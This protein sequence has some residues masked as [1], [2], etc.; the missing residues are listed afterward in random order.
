MPKTSSSEDFKLST[1]V[2]QSV[3]GQKLILAS[4]SPTRIKL[5]ENA[6]L[7]FMSQHPNIDEAAEQALRAHFTANLLAIE[8]AKL[9]A[10]SIS[11]NQA[12]IIGA[13]QTL[14]CCGITYHKPKNKAEAYGQ[15]TSLR[16]KTHTLT[17]AVAISY[18]N[19]ILWQHSMQAH[20]TMRNFSDAFLELYIDKNL[21]DILTTVGCYQLEGAGINLFEKIEGDYFTILGLPLLPCLAYLRRLGFSQS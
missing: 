13:D 8:L 9:K 3:Q 16:G 17:S 20:L 21:I 2:H 1:I 11:K 4:T 7:T 18:E 19:E 12:Y 6:G 10:L 5:L 14:D 15:L